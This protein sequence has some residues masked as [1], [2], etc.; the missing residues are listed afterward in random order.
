[1]TSENQALKE[2]VLAAEQQLIEV[3][4]RRNVDR[5][6]NMKALENMRDRVQA[7]DD[8]S[9]KR[10]DPSDP[11]KSPEKLNVG[12]KDETYAYFVTK[13]AQHFPQFKAHAAETELLVWQE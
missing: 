10:V 11:S 7:V 3:N 9:L 4:R 5:T 12:K 13:F 8:K 2:Q 1:M 6:E